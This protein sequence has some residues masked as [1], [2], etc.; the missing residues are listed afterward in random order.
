MKK[1]KKNILVNMKK[2]YQNNKE[3]V[4]KRNKLWRLKNSEKVKKSTNR[5]YQKN[6]EEISKK[7]KLWGLKNKEKILSK[8]RE[9]YNLNKEKY[10]ERNKIQKVKHREKNLIRSKIYNKKYYKR[11]KKILIEKN[12]KYKRK[13]RKEDI[14]FRIKTNLRRRLLYVLNLY[15]NGK[16]LPTSKYGINYKKIINHL[17]PFPKEISKYHVDHIIPLCTF[18]LTNPI[19]IKEAFAPEN[20]QWLLAKE[21]LSKGGKT[22]WQR[23][24]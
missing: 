12:N 23:Q 11:N 21:N 16:K 13:R 17:K 18:D 7:K 2:Y 15:G 8:K 9:D 5:Y 4:L 1:T 19:Q 22:N 3:K 14:Q 6:K 10:K 24:Y 20:H